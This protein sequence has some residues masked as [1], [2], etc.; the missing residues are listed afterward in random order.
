[1]TSHKNF[2][3]LKQIQRDEQ[4]S[5]VVTSPINSNIAWKKQHESSLSLVLVAKCPCLKLRDVIWTHPLLQVETTE[6][7]T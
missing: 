6:T 4:V 5:T 7:W 3:P 2:P 1:M